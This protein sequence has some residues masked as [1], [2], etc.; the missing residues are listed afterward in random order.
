MC[1]LKTLGLVTPYIMPVQERITAN[2]AEA[3]IHCVS[4]RHLSLSTNFDFAEVEES[5][6][7]DL[8]QEVA[9]SK[10]AAIMTLCTN[11]RAA[12]L[13]ATLEAQLGI[14][15]LDSTAAAVWKS[16]MLAGGDPNQIQGW[17]Q[18]F[19]A[20][21]AVLSPAIAANSR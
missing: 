15:L 17:G 18:L 12:P 6:L 19:S 10:P 8:I 14:P 20:G 21:L 16:L 5:V 3:G 7:T 2:F 13:A 1:N 9:K 4:E 11:L